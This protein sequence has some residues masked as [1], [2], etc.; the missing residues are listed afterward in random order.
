MENGN[1]RFL[2]KLIHDWEIPYAEDHCYGADCEAHPSAE[3]WLLFSPHNLD[4]EY[5]ITDENTD[6]S[7]GGG[8]DGRLYLSH[9]HAGLWVIDIETLMAAGAEDNKTEVYSEATVAFYLPHGQD[10]SQLDS[11]YYDF[12]WTPFLWAAE[13]QDGI[14][15]ASCITT[16]LYVMQL[17]ID[18]PYT[19]NYTNI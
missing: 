14:T 18:V 4:S 5:F 9:Y 11:D 16:G 3:E 10:G 17:D 8:W 2:P 15:Y 13:W 6:T 1:L 7:H 19:N 12:G